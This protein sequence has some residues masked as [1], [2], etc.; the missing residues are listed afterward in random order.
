LTGEVIATKKKKSRGKL[1][2][3]KKRKQREGG[4]TGEEVL[5]ED[6]A[7][8]A[9]THDKQSAHRSA[10]SV[11][12]VKPPKKKRKADKEDEKFESLVDTYR[13]AFSNAVGSTTSKQDGK[14][15]FED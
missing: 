14:R 3:E 12:K 13:T 9:S 11:K 1:Q 2:R 7:V 15:W 10:D 5:D 6:T 4:T 8:P